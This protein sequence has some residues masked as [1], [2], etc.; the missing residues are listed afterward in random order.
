MLAQYRRLREEGCDPKESV[1]AALRHSGRGIVTTSLAL[2][3][4]FLTLMASAWQTLSSFGFF[5]AL[6]ILGALV[7]VLFLL[8][9]LILTFARDEASGAT[10][11]SGGREARGTAWH[12]G[13]LVLAIVVPAAIGV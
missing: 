4:G 11:G 13:L 3:L 6:A 5:V 8:P 12:R 7:A 1:C 9:A 10:T 2:A